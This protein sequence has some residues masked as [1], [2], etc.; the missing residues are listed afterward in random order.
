[1]AWKP[2]IPTPE[3]WFTNPPITSGRSVLSAAMYGMR[4]EDLAKLPR[5]DQ[6]CTAGHSMC[7]VTTIGRHLTHSYLRAKDIIAR[8]EA[9]ARWARAHRERLL[10]SLLV[11]LP[12][13]RDVEM[14]TPR[15]VAGVEIESLKNLDQMWRDSF[16][17]VG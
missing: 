15:N 6:A 17:A 11:P 5:T 4:S 3:E 10:A 7:I 8:A 14:R 12:V 2:V 13:I 9:K 16:Y 1:M